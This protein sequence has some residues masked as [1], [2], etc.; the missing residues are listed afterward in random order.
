MFQSSIEDTT[1]PSFHQ[2]RLTIQLEHSLSFDIIIVLDASVGMGIYPFTFLQL[3]VG[4]YNILGYHVAGTNY[5]H[6]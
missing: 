3:S 4:H 6:I 5:F 2:I 1:I